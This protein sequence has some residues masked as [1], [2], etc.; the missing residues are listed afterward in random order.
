M[1][2]G[3]VPKLEPAALLTDV[4]I[5]NILEMRTNEASFQKLQ[6]VVVNNVFFDWLSR[7]GCWIKEYVCSGG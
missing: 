1:V 6:L 2:K 7:E 5:H 3:E 4:H